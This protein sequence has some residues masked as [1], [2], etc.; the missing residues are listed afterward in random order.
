MYCIPIFFKYLESLCSSTY[1]QTLTYE[2]PYAN[3]NLMLSEFTYALILDYN[4]DPLVFYSMTIFHI[5]TILF[6]NYLV[7]YLKVPL[8]IVIAI[9]Y[10][11]T[12]FQR[13]TIFPAEIHNYPQYSWSSCIFCSLR[14]FLA[15]SS[16]YVLSY[17]IKAIYYAYKYA[18]IKCI[19]T[20][21]Y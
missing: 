9:Y 18:L 6:G 15:L 12:Q 21:Y 4:E 10:V 11:K 17:T 7:T 13:N 1:Y 19:L 2:I 5:F 20:L 8:L 16:H 3:H 14:K